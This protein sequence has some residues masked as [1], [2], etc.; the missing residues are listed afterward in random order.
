MRNIERAL[1]SAGLGKIKVSTVVTQTILA[2]SYPPSIGV[3]HQDAEPY[4][5]SIVQ[6][7]AVTD[8][9]LLAN[10]HPYYAYQYEGGHNIAISYALFTSPGTVVKDGSYNYQNLFDAMVD[11]LYAALERADGENVRIVVAESGWPWS[12]MMAATVENSRTYYEN[13]ISHVGQGT[14][15][16]PGVPLQ[17]YLYSMFD[18]DC[19]QFGLFCHDK[20]ALHS[21][22]FS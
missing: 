20:K 13:L 2:K 9:P 21:I 18:E 10:V 14:P 22:A 7:L 19:K 16:R 5:K 6:F 8:A 12:G 3:F 17:T 1:S 11:A 15:R 4:I